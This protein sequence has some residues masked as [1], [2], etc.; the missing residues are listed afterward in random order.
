LAIKPSHK[1]AGF[2]LV[3]ILCVLALLG[4]TAGLVVLNLPKPAPVFKSEVQG[5]ATLINLAARESVIDGKSRGLDLTT[6]GIDILQYDGEWVADRQ[7]NFESV[8]GLDL[9]VEDQSIDLVKREKLKEK[10]ELPPLI[11]L[12][13]TGTMTPFIL[14]INGREESFSLSPDSR[15]RI[16]IE[17]VL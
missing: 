11:Y 15:G 7:F 10:S 16:V 5:V 13:A 1:E 8:Y 17:N 9:L 12:D 6:G 2:T 14:E 4:L 3:E